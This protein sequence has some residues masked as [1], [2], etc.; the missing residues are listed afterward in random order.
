MAHVKPC[1]KFQGWCTKEDFRFQVDFWEGRLQVL[2]SVLQLG[3][4]FGWFPVW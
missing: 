4:F 1:L 2:W 3:L